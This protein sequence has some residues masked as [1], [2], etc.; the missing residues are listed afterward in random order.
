M[1]TYAAALH[2]ELVDGEDDEREAGF[3]V[4]CDFGENVPKDEA[5]F[6]ALNDDEQNKVLRVM[7]IAAMAKVN[8]QG[9][10][11]QSMGTKA[12][13]MADTLGGVVH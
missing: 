12:V 8:I 7:T 13:E 11:E 10:L 6:N 9:F 5:G 2:L 1:T 3:Y 4:S